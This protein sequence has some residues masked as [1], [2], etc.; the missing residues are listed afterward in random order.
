MSGRNTPQQMIPLAPAQGG[1]QAV[2]R[3]F[4]TTFEIRERL[5]REIR[6]YQDE[7]S[8]AYRDYSTGN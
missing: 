3:A 7:L 4:P 5:D 6:E 8:K 1:N 2:R